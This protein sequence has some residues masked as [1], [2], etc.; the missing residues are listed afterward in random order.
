MI[1]KIMM[2]LLSYEH[3]NTEDHNDDSTCSYVVTILLLFVSSSLPKNDLK[4]SE[5]SWFL[6]QKSSFTNENQ[7]FSGW[8]K[9]SHGGAA[10]AVQFEPLRESGGWKVRL[11][12]ENQPMLLG[13]GGEPG[14]TF[15]GTLGEP[16][17]L[18][19]AAQMVVI[20][21]GEMTR[22]SWSQLS[23]KSCFKPFLVHVMSS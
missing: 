17:E 19:E 16:G 15:G 11:G 3:T 6:D 22:K 20:Y 5:Q 4:W 21:N 7:A 10:G 9:T 14:G 8:S 18:R 12:L 13:R 2:L 23:E 1:V